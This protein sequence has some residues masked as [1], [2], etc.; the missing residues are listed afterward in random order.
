MEFVEVF[1]NRRKEFVLALT[2]HAAV[3]VDEANIK[4]TAI[5][6]RTAELS[7]RCAT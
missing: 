3:S 4:L 6:E 7:Q 1:V 5:D 2:I